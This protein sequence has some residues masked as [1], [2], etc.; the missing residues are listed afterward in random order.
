[1]QSRLDKDGEPTKICWRGNFQ[2]HGYPILHCLY[3]VILSRGICLSGPL[4]ATL[5]RRKLAIDRNAL[6]Y[7]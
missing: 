6:Y 2:L 4:N 5:T 7:V 3:V 1:M